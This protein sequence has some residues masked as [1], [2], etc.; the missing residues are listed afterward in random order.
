MAAS[1]LTTLGGFAFKVDG[2]SLDSP[3]TRKA[4]ALM[5]YLIMNRGADSARERLLEIFWPDADPDNA[6][7]SLNTALHSIR[8]SLRAAGV[9]ADSF[10]VA[11]YSVVRWT[12]ETTVDA[13]QFGA[14]AECADPAAYQ[15]ALQLYSGDF[16]EGDYDDWAVGER[17]RLATLYE[18][19][20]AKAVRG[21]RDPEAARRLLARNPY[22][23]E[24]YAVL[25]E[26]EL[27]AGRGPSATALVARCRKALSE[28]DEKPSAAFEDR[29]GH[30]GRRSLDVPGTNL[31]PETTS[32]VGRGAELSEVRALLTK[33]RLVT[34]VGVGGVGKTRVALHVGAQL[35]NTF[36]DGAWFVDLAKVSGPESV[37]PEIASAYGITS[38]G[39]SALFDR[40][41]AHMKHRRL[42]LILDNCEHVV[43]EAA[44]VASSVVTTCPH[45]TILA[46][47][48]EAPLGVGGE[49]VY[50]LP[51]L[52]VPPATEPKAENA[53]KFS[54]VELFVERARTVD[55]HFAF[56][57]DNASAV[58]E[59]CRR[60]DGIA[61]AIELAAAR[62]TTLSVHQ[63]LERLREQFQFLKGVDRAAHPR[64]QTMRATLDWSYEWLTEAERAMF[65]RLAIFQGGFMVE[66]VP[67]AWDVE[68][69]DG[70]SVLDNLS[71]LVNKSLVAVKFSAQSQRYRLLEPLRQYGLER[72]KE[73][74]EFDATAR[75]HAQYFAAFARQAADNWGKIAELTWL[76]NI[77]SE[78]DNFRAA[79]EW[80]LSQNNDPVLGAQIA[81]CLGNFWF[82]RHYHEGLRWLELAQA[83]VTYEAYPALSVGIAVVR[84]RSYVQ[85]DLMAA[86]RVCEE[87][88]GPARTLGDVH[89]LARL[90]NLYCCP[91]IVLNRLDEA[92]AVCSESLEMAER[93]D[94]HHRVAFNLWGLSKI[95]RK[96]GD[97]DAARQFS[98]KMAE[99]YARRDAPMDR[100]RWMVF[101]E[102]A[103][104]EQ[105]DGHIGRAIEICREAHTVAELTKDPLADA[106]VLYY[107][108]ALLLISGAVDQACTQGAS[109][110]KLSREELLS[111]G[112]AYA[113]QVLSGVAMARTEPETAARLLGYAEEWFRKQTIPRDFWIEVDPEW[114]IQPLRDHFGNDRLAQLMAEGA[115]WSED[116]AV[117][118]A[119]KVKITP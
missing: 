18:S 84:V 17:E 53:L 46:T 88:L 57:E 45:V 61:L 34:I 6:R 19:V 8:H 38:Q 100:N 51:P 14:L 48:R 30:I 74:H 56:T 104:L 86:L 26:T 75:R 83:A 98:V 66:A 94:D 87:A 36:D 11:T 37:V 118:E 40:V 64:H 114:F 62:V 78:I 115:A 20:L 13:R 113:I 99:A 73:H 29:F 119:L 44:R 77:E 89:L 69:P 55:P 109:L 80:S 52:D 23:E 50:P 111:H 32:F 63:L 82:S 7:K 41:L 25:I 58:T 28:V 43:V 76:S 47:S 16:L 15:E 27:V 12:A 35:R 70:L 106:H 85:A 1:T 21:N 60:L 65:R 22:A 105:S 102:R 39:F 91:L 9:E 96:R 42:L 31:P 81:A 107:L 4:R 97:L 112:I 103:R 72:L 67:A 3:A 90:L 71:S 92:A 54:A 59:I 68:Q 24:A 2:I 49:Q 117:E 108:G 33:S 101:T 5:A 116:Q 110:L 93:T 95:S 10:L 79:L